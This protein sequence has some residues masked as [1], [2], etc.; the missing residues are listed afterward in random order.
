MRPD[1]ARALV[2]HLGQR[3]RQDVQAHSGVNLDHVEAR[4]F[5]REWRNESPEMGNF[6]RQ[7]GGVL[8]DELA[9]VLASAKRLGLV[10]DAGV[11][12]AADAETPKP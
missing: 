2:A 12:A 9:A 6:W 10:L 7:P 3:W 4:G 5:L 8:V 11:V 1:A